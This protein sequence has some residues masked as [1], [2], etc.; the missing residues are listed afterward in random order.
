MK[1]KL[2]VIRHAHTESKQ[3]GHTDHERNLTAKGRG[4]ALRVAA[5][6]QQL[7]WTP[8]LTLCSD[9]SR[10]Q[11]TWEL[12]SE[13]FESRVPTTHTNALYL[14]DVDTVLD[15]LFGLDEDTIEVAVLGH[16]PGWQN[17]V[18]WLSGVAVRMSPGT[19]VLL[20]GVGDTWADALRQN[21]W[22]LGEVIRPE[23]L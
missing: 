21:G 16:N 20:E 18:H 10:T 14:A 7:G 15:E 4:D 12:M 9:A 8:Q 23:Q 6:I 3:P 11:Q 19:A 2:L 13:V 17:L 5:R 1:R 22:E